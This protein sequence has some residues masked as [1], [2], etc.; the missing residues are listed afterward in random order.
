VRL[1]HVAPFFAPAPGYGGMARA[2]AA[3]CC[4][5]AA[6]GH[7]VTVAT[8]L[9]DPVLPPEE[10]RS[11]VRIHRF[12]TPAALGS[13]LFPWAPAMGRWIAR[14]LESADV[15]HLHGHRN[16]L[17]VA[18]A[19]AAARAGVPVVLQP[20]GT[21]PDHGQRRAAKRLFD[22]AVGDWIVHA[23][24]AVI[25]V[26][27]AEQRDLPRPSTRVANGVEPP[28]ELDS[29]PQRERVPGSLLFVGNGDHQKRGQ[30]LPAVLAA[31][32]SATLRL[33]GRFRQPFLR[34][35]RPFR[36]RVTVSGVLDDGAL[37]AAYAQA[38]LVVHPAV[39]E[40]FGFVPFEAALFGTAAVVAGGHG[41]GEWYGRAGGCVAAPDDPGAL[42]EKVRHRL[43]DPGLAAAESAAVADFVHRELTW[44]RAAE[45]VERLYLGLRS[46]QGAA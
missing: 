30:H 4:A 32:P 12:P 39:G 44:S 18:A 24:S 27:E 2:A 21:Y 11:G 7:E 9:L 35:F 15:V 5:L 8:A 20:H 29:R 28:G 26:S 17:A 16:G 14:A 22:R 6:R 1:L 10:W 43:D 42:I 45:A 25:A 46:A 36:D 37:S 41:C 13:R 19:R 31:V 3:L 23:A 33:V 38:R 40:A 34:A